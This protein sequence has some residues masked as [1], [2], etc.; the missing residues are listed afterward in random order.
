MATLESRTPLTLPIIWAGGV[1]L[2]AGTGIAL[3]DA[4]MMLVLAVAALAVS[5]PFLLSFTRPR[6]VIVFEV[7]LVVG[8]IPNVIALQTGLPVSA[9]TLVI[10]LLIAVLARR[11]MGV[12]SVNLPRGSAWM[13]VGIV[14]AA[15]LS[16]VFASDRARALIEVTDL[17]ESVVLTGLMLALLSDAAW[18]RRGIWAFAGAGGLLAGL[19]VFQQ[20]TGTYG[21]DYLGFAIVEEDHGLQRAAGPLDPNFFG[22]VLVA[23]G[24]LALYLWL[25]SRRGAARLAALAL[26]VA[27]AAGIVFTYSRGSFLAAA[28]VL[29]AVALLRRIP[30]WLPATGLAIIIVAGAALL[31]VEA[32]TRLSEMTSTG[33]AAA[34]ATDESI[35]NRFAE[36]VAAIHMFGD[37]PLTGVGPNNYPVR[38]LDYSQRIGLDPRAEERTGVG[39]E[40]HNLY[41]EVLAETGFV[42]T[43]A[44]FVVIGAALKGAWRGRRAL[45]AGDGLLAEGVFVALVGFLLNSLFLHA[46]YPR[47]FWILIGF[48]LI[49]A[50]LAR[51]STPT[52]STR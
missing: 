32:K 15:A 36:N 25:S 38:Y 30:L 45:P 13:L 28:V 26:T 11:L 12:E 46:A 31:P 24:A 17:V 43:L 23:A 35:S 16:A 6:V 37:F 44:F 1:L 51:H 48:G 7:F 2:A 4:P 5:L 42:G 50:K 41:L 8:F 40:P 27:S 14:A 20:V 18:L 47:Y 19:A 29:V 3:A 39:Q 52:R 33:D 49:C 10:L 21:G 22:M 9:Q 34:S